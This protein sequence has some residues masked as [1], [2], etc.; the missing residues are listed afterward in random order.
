MDE[1]AKL[2]PEKNVKKDMAVPALTKALS[3]LKERKALKSSR[4]V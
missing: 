4:A 2:M 3:T 1:L